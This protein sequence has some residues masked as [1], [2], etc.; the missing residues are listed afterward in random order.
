MM[1]R[2]AS[3]NERPD[4]EPSLGR[5]LMA[6]ML[7]AAVLPPVV[8]GS[9]AVGLVLLL[10]NRSTARPLTMADFDG[11]V[12]ALLLATLAVVAL[13]A[14]I[15]YWSTRRLAGG[16]I[17]PLRE[18]AAEADRLAATDLPRLVEALRSTDGSGEIPVVDLIDVQADGEV[19]DLVAAF[20]S[21]RSATI[22]TVASQA[23]GRS[24]DLAGVL[25]NLG[26]RNQRLIGRQLQLIDRLEATESDPD[27]LRHLFSLDQMATRMRRN[28]ES[29]LVLAGERV[30]RQLEVPLPIDEVL[31][32]ATSEVEQYHRVT[33]AGV[34][35]ATVS[36]RA[37]SDL[38][39]LLAELIENA[40][41]F[42][43]PGSP[44][45]LMGRW[46]QRG[47][48]TVSVVDE[49]A[50]MSRRELAEANDRITSAT[51]GADSPTS[52]LGLFVVGRLAARHQIDTR[53]V[54]SA[55]SGT[56]AKVTLPP[57]IVAERVPLTENPHAA[58][59]H[60]PAPVGR[61][62]GPRPPAVE[63]TLAPI[64]G[65]LPRITVD[66][67]VG[68]QL[69]APAPERRPVPGPRPAA[70]AIEPLAVVEEDLTLAADQSDVGADDDADALPI[71]PFRARTSLV[72]PTDHQAETDFGP[73][74]DTND[75]GD[76]PIS[77][78]VGF[79]DD[80]DVGHQYAEHVESD[81]IEP[82]AGPVPA[83]R[84]HPSSAHF[85]RP[86]PGTAGHLE[87]VP[88]PKAPS[89]CPDDRADEVR[90]RLAGFCEGVAAAMAGSGPASP[91]EDD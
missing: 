91:P 83:R 89:E 32:A 35:A 51:V 57:H 53:L 40:T 90:Q 59:S 58:E 2:H 63:S 60:E 44:V 82:D 39:H 22:D 85:G 70:A 48:Y 28:A 73:V 76:G 7:T 88:P 69:R 52:Y 21:L 56:I 67:P 6:A 47:G 86:G 66:G 26:R 80:D 3:V 87:V 33:Q 45:L 46:E 74:I 71:P 23:I 31:R 49:G 30:D 75:E 55:P 38:T 84:H 27:M 79:D 29:L 4:N 41:G 72:G 62:R 17:G 65:P 42:S 14:L 18:L 37:V 10:S 61:R 54:E 16:I 78:S 64:T 24:R 9:L 81:G 12:I 34:Q 15:S 50:G 11:A 19:A 20:N 43:D 25:V 1:R 13:T 8:V 77:A 36:P 68:A 5:R